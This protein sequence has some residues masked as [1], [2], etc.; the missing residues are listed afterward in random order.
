MRL[1]QLHSTPESADPVSS[2]VYSAEAGDVSTVIIDG[3]LVLND[4]ELTTINEHAIVKD[5]NR[6]ATLLKARA[7][8][9]GGSAE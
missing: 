1:D 7:G 3:R 9:D 4:G 8:L 5:A 2:I 6:E